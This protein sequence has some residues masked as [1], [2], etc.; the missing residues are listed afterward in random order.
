MPAVPYSRADTAAT[1]ESFCGLEACSSVK[2]IL[3]AAR[4]HYFDRSH[5]A[6]T[7]LTALGP[8]RETMTFERENYRYF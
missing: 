3:H 2:V 8:V 6:P 4:V 5:H 7:L 1:G